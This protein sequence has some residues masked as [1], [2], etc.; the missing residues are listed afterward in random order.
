MLPIIINRCGQRID[1]D[2]RVLMKLTRQGP[3]CEYEWLYCSY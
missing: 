3:G 1:R 2:A